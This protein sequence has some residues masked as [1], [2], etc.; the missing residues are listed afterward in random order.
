V[1]TNEG[2]LA[3]S[4]DLAK[5]W[6]LEDRGVGRAAL[7]EDAPAMGDEE[8]PRLALELVAEAAIA[9]AAI[10]VLPVPVAETSRFRWRS[11]RSRWACNCSSIRA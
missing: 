11:W 3:V 8:Q 10:T 7:I 5:V 1:T 9:S 2:L 4:K 6:V